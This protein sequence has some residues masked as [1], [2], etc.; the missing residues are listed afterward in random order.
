MS[1]A[2][3]VGEAKTIQEIFK[4]SNSELIG[5]L[6]KGMHLDGGGKMTYYKDQSSKVLMSIQSLIKSNQGT[7]ENIIR[8]IAKL[9]YEMDYERFTA[10]R[11]SMLKRS[12]LLRLRFNSNGKNIDLKTYSLALKEALDETKN[13]SKKLLDGIS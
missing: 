3:R 13:H 6:M 11:S 9:L 5:N 7:P 8:N 4:E 2:R 12:V 1:E 10:V